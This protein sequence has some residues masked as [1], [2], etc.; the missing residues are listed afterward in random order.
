MAIIYK[1]KFL[2]KNIKTNLNP[3]LNLKFKLYNININFLNKLI[4]EYLNNYNINIFIIYIYSNKTF[5][6]IYN[7]TIFNLYKKFLKIINKII[8]IYKILL[9]KKNQLL[10]YNIYQLLNIIY[11][12]IKNYI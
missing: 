1:C 12:N 6:I 8:L 3:I 11:N 5:K 4:T 2:I 10:F 9:Y 7:Y